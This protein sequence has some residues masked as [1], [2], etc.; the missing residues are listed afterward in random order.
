MSRS[1]ARPLA[2]LAALSLLFLAETAQATVLLNVSGVGSTGQLLQSRT[3]AAVSFTLDQS[4]TSVSISAD[5]VCVNCSGK[6][7]LMKDRVGPTATLAD[8]IT[9]E[10][11]K[12]SSGTS[13][14]FSGLDL[15]RGEYFLI[16]ANAGDTGA[17]GWT[18]ADPATITMLA[19]ITRGFDLYAGSLDSVTYNSG[20]QGVLGTR[21]LLYSIT[22]DAAG[23]TSAVPEPGT[24]MLMILGFG[25]TAFHLRRSR[26]KINPLPA[27][28]QLGRA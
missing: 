9:G 14:L 22:G 4:Y 26:S 18:G 12:E 28:S 6:V 19:G 17:A 20:F 8:F 15:S 23:E 7:V 13:P 25:L 5:L 24:W 3:A 27:P 2:R 11:L 10:S 1:S 16:F 21:A